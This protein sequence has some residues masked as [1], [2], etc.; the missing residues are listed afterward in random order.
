[1][2][3]GQPGPD[4]SCRFRTGCRIVWCGPPD[5]GSILAEHF[6][7]LKRQPVID[8]LDREPGYEGPLANTHDQARPILCDRMSADLDSAKEPHAMDPADVIRDSRPVQRQARPRAHCMQNTDRRY[9]QIPFY[10]YA[11]D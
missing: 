6:M 9:T 7:D 11:A 3:R 5:L 1:M 10:L 4:D 8:A 2:P